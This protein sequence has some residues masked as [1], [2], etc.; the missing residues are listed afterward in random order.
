MLTQFFVALE[1][2]LTDLTD[3]KDDKGATMIEYGMICGLI[4]AV[5]VAAMLLLGDSIELLFER[6]SARIGTALA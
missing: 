5:V 3:R 4:I 1:T 2:L 6:V